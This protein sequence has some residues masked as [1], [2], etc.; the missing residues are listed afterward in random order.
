MFM[1]INGNSCLSSE[2]DNELPYNQQRLG[3]FSYIYSA[4][5][6]MPNRRSHC[7]HDTKRRRLDKYKQ[8]KKWRNDVYFRAPIALGGTDSSS[9]SSTGALC[10]GN[11]CL[12][13]L[14]IWKVQVRR[15]KCRYVGQLSYNT[16]H[17]INRCLLP[18]S[19]VTTCTT[20][21]CHPFNHNMLVLP[22]GAKRHVPWHVSPANSQSWN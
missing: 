14:A 18:T 6:Q 11:R 22:I 3:P 10:R 19:D 13:L 5:I 8:R 2:S 16:E 21:L 12:H 1:N 15:Q 7:S 20:L 4:G 17:R 9:D